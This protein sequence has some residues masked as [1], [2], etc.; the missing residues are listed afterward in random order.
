MGGIVSLFFSAVRRLDG[1][2][3]VPV[4]F[5]AVVVED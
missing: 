1:G 5:G 3:V 2:I 4:R